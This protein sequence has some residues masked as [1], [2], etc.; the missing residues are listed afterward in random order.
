LSTEDLFSNTNNKQ[1]TPPALF[2]N[3]DTQAPVIDPNRD[4]LEEYVGEGKKFRDAADLARGKAHSDVFIA[5]L[6][7][8]ME[9]LRQ[10]LSTRLKL[11]EFMDRMN[12]KNS[13]VGNEQITQTTAT[14]TSDGTANNPALSPDDIEKVVEQ[15]L[16]AK[17]QELRT[18]QNLSMTKE[19]LQEA[20]GENY[21]AELENRVSTL[22]LSKDLVNQLA[23]TEPRALFAML[24]LTGQQ[25]ARQQELLPSAPRGSVNTASMGLAAPAEKTYKDYEKLRKQNPGEYWS[26]K[27]QSDMHRQAL[28]LGERFYS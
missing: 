8:E 26:A 1:E 6:Q 17:E 21:A 28:K 10:E 22:G 7:K 5:R 9:G 16:R 11:E 12:S 25:Q 13:T 14:A 27:V 15:K 4:W 3:E 20:F 19:K 23:K 18:Q 24:G 2:E